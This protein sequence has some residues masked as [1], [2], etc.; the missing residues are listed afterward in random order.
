MDKPKKDKAIKSKEDIK[1]ISTKKCYF[2]P[3]KG[4]TIE[5]DSLEDAIGKLDKKAE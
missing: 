2:F 5:A 3:S 1:K 4:V